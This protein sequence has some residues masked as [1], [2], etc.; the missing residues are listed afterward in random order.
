MKEKGSTSNGSCTNQFVKKGYQ[1]MIE[2]DRQTEQSRQ[3]GPHTKKEAI[4]LQGSV[5]NHTH[6]RLQYMAWVEYHNSTPTTIFK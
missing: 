5:L 1:L 6:R 2:T 4:S 3:P